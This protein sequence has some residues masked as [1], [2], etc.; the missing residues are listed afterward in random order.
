MIISGLQKM[1]STGL[2]LR[3]LAM[4]SSWEIIIGLWR[5]CRGRI[6][7]SWRICARKEKGTPVRKAW[8]WRNWES[9]SIEAKITGWTL[10]PGSTTNS[11][12]TWTARTSWFPSTCWERSR[13]S[14]RE[15]PKS[16]ENDRGLPKKKERGSN[17]DK[18]RRSKVQRKTKWREGG[19]NER[20]SIQKDSC[21]IF[22][23]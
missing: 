15:R 12:R 19:E 7:G 2:L 9:S 10:K 22:K 8:P 3:G 1:P 4:R 5:G 11:I 20:C 13:R 6:I 14:R 23:I 18:E 21:N 17:S 16:K